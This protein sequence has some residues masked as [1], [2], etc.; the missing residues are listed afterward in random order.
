M[1]RLLEKAGQ[2]GLPL[3]I[4]TIADPNIA[5]KGRAKLSSGPLKV[6]GFKVGNISEKG[7][8]HLAKNAQGGVQIEFALSSLRITF[9]SSINH[10]TVDD[11]TFAVPDFLLSIERRQNSRFQVLGSH[12]AFVSMNGW[13]PHPTDAG[14]PPYFSSAPELSGL[15]PVSDV[16]LGG[17]SVS[18]RFPAICGLL[19]EASSEKLMNLHL[20]MMKPLEFS[21]Y[22]RW[23][24]KTQDVVTELDGRSRMV[25]SYRFGMQFINPSEEVLS[26]VRGFIQMITQ[27]EAI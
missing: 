14:T 24:R 13:D 2:T 9:Y 17:V 23:Q 4:R 26:G 10:F 12:R 6:N 1:S 19:G 5:V 25:S 20:P 21:V 8:A 22:V 15:L 18:D 11:C 27:A 3:L 16:S 7:L